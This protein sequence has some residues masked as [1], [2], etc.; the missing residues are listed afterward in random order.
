M[1]PASETSRLSPM[2][3]PVPFNSKYE[4]QKRAEKEEQNKR[5]TPPRAH[6]PV[7][8]RGGVKYQQQGFD[9]P[10]KVL[11]AEAFTY[12]QITLPH[13][14]FIGCSAASR[15]HSLAEFIDNEGL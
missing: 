9:H 6:N 14:S 12:N 11:A 1:R 10:A 2:N 4:K 8:G 3:Q 15:R 7:P 13:R 5:Q